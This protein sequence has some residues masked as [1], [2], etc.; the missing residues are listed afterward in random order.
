MVVLSNLPYNSSLDIDFGSKTWLSLFIPVVLYKALN[1]DFQAYD[2]PLPVGPTNIT[3]CY[4]F[5][6]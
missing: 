4:N 1:N 3:P 2:L 5:N 6:I